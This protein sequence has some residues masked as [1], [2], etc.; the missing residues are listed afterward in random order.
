MAI[1]VTLQQRRTRSEKM[2]VPVRNSDKL[3]DPT[4]S[5]QRGLNPTA[6]A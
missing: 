1:S 2:P 6:L 3:L 5:R 4:Q